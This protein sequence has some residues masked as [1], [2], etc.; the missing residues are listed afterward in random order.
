[1]DT[2]PRFERHAHAIYELMKVG[3]DVEQHLPARIVFVT[4]PE[5]KARLEPALDRGNVKQ[6]MRQPATAIVAYD[7]EFY[8][9]CRCSSRTATRKR[10]SSASRADRVRGDA[11]RDAAGG[12]SSSPPAR[13]DSIADRWE[14]STM[15]S[16]TPSS[17]RRE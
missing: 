3:S 15:R 11:E 6:T 14:A 7:L 8:E 16:S 17:S 10:I 1:M 5:G 13:S 12:Y 2:A 9:S 4:T